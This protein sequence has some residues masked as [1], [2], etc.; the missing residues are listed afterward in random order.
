M[1]DLFVGR[2]KS[3]DGVS[4]GLRDEARVLEG[5]RAVP[6]SGSGGRGTN[7]EPHRLTPVASMLAMGLAVT[8]ASAADGSYLRNRIE[9]EYP[10]VLPSTLA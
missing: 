7:V 6:S 5:I 4:G 10:C 3:W 1:I 9:E 2:S 8:A